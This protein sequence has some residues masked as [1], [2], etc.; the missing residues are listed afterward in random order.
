MLVNR[1]SAVSIC[2]ALTQSL[3]FAATL[4]PVRATGAKFNILN[5]AVAS[6]NP[7]F[8][9]SGGTDYLKTSNASGQLLANN[10]DWKNSGFPTPV[11]IGGNAR[12]GNGQC[13]DFVKHASGTNSIVASSWKRGNHVSDYWDPTALVGQAIATFDANGNYDSGHVAII[14]SAWK[15]SGSN[16]VTNVWVAD[17]NW[18]GGAGSLI[19]GRHGININGSSRVSNLKNYYLVNY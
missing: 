12:V 15:A 18:V 8:V 7:F 4:T 6:T 13:V 3:S 19:V 16:T 14:L 5:N 10:T 11:S 9:S 2:F 17:A 1:R